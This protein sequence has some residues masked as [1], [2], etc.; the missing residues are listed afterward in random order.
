VLGVYG[1]EVGNV[2]KYVGFMLA[3]TLAYRVLGWL[4]L[5]LRKH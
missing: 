4:V 3:I 5:Y 1:Y 2:G